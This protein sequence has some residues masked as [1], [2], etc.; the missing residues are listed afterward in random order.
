VSAI[1]PLSFYA[2]DVLDVARELVGKHL[3]ANG[4]ELRITEVEAYRWPG[5]TACHARSGRTE[6][7]AAIWGPPGRAYVYLVYGLHQ[8][9]NIV[10][11]EDGDAQAVL[12]RACE[13]VRGL[14]KIRERRGGKEGPV[15]LA[16][17]GKVAQA[18][19][20]DT[21]WSHHELHREGG[22]T[23]RDGPP[24]SRV[25]VGPRV[26]IDYAEPAH[27]VLPWR[28]AAADTPWITHARTLQPA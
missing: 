14:A 15:L 22:L 4:V 24:P 23:L 5:D 25:L 6:R 11:G 8:M 7:N 9:L 13:P 3:R 28:F 18:L 17:P 26:G 16:G 19:G 20:I 12:V 1:L 21:S 10:T 27:R 2:R